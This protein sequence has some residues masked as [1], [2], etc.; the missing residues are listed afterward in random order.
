MGVLSHAHNQGRKVEHMQSKVE[1]MQTY[2]HLKQ[3]FFTYFKV[4]I[5]IQNYLWTA[6]FCLISYDLYVY[7]NFVSFFF[8]FQFYHATVI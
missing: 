7:I 8:F 2:K 3:T 4:C 5:S 6:L 1:H